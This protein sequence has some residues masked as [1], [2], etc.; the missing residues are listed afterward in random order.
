MLG[1]ALADHVLLHITGVGIIYLLLYGSTKILTEQFHIHGL[2]SG[3][4]GDGPK[5]SIRFWARQAAVY[6]ACLLGMKIAVV[7]L[8]AVWPG[9]FS[10]GEWLLSWT[11]NSD[12]VQVVV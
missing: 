7:I 2:Q 10:I 9:I 12:L 4:Y 11:G 3:Q 5:P 6:V 1:C 8:F